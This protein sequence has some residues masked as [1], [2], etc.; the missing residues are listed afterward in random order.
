MVLPSVSAGKGQ[1]QAPLP[2]APDAIGVSTEAPPRCTVTRV[3]V[4]RQN[5][6]RWE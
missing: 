4:S 5:W 6:V 1:P 2:P 3:T